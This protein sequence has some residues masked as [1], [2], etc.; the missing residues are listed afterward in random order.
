MRAPAAR[1]VF[2][3]R[4]KAAATAGSMPSKNTFLTTA[5]L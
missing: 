3:V 4:S 2:S 1:S 5:S